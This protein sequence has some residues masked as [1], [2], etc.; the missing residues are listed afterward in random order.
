MASQTVCD[1]CGVVTTVVGERWHRVETRGAVRV[2][3]ARYHDLC[4]PC[5][6]EG[7][8]AMYRR[9]ER[10][11]PGPNAVAPASRFEAQRRVQLPPDQPRPDVT[12][13]AP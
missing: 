4:D 1:V 2:R 9:V 3:D 13:E 8:E 6:Q 11:S 10:L 7:E 12:G 5:W